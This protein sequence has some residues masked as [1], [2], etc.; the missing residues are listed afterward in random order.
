MKTNNTYLHFV[1]Y[2]D[3]PNWSVGYILGHSIGF[4][5]KYPLVKIGKFLH[6]NKTSVD[7]QDD[8]LYKRVTI[9]TLGGGICLRD[10]EKGTNIG[11]KKQF[12]ISKGQ[13]LVSKIDA[14]KGAFGVV[15]NEVD[16]AIITG[17]FWTYDVDEN[18]INPYFLA[19]LTSTKTFAR[20]SETASVGT[21]NRRYL[22]EDLFLQQQ[23]PLP[24]LEEQQALVD[25]YNHNLQQATDLEQQ[26]EN[27]EKEIENY[28]L[29]RLEIC[30]KKQRIRKGLNF[31]KFKDIARW[32]FESLM[33][34][35]SIKS[36]YAMVSFKSLLLPIIGDTTKIQEK[37]IHKE[38]KYP[39]ITQEKGR[40]IAGYTDNDKLVTDLPLVIFGD[41]SCAFKYVDFPFVRGADGT[42]LLKFKKECNPLFYAYFLPIIH[43]DNQE[44]YQRHYKYLENIEIPLPPLDVQAEIVAE[45]QAQRAKIAEYKTTSV[46]LRKDAITQFEQAIFE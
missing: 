16:G 6:R 10:T 40:L 4:T 18:V 45:V 15:P 44:K 38:G 34:D 42:K 28:L 39:V 27:G 43:I 1:A 32:D 41:H 24:S 30:T 9:K 5:Q 31:V 46:T 29:S 17:N 23:I 22:Q 7:I 35:N 36:K 20:F 2:K 37:E 12:L 25:A 33:I 13:F 14:R 26:A 11:T 21:T 3:I 19:Y 8:V